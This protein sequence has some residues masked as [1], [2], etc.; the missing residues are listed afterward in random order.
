MGVDTCI[1]RRSSE[2]FVLPVRDVLVGAWVA[3]TFRETEI[4]NMQYICSLSQA[5][6]KVVWFHVP[7]NEILIVAILD[8]AA[9]EKREGR[10]RKEEGGSGVCKWT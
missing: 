10:R 7:V 4:D 9:K 8:A 6:Q 3:I 2:I 5:D 1:P